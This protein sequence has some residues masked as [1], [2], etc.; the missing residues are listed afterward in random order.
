MVTIEQVGNVASRSQ[1]INMAVDIYGNETSWIRPLNLVVSDAIS[2][3]KNPFYANGCGK[4]FIAKKEGK[5]V[6]RILVHM[7]K[8]HHLIHQEKV[9]YF[10]LFECVDDMD[11]AKV[12]LNEA[13]FFAKS[14]GCKILRG[15]FNITAAQEIGILTDGFD[16]VPSIDMVYTKPY[17]PTLLKESGFIPCLKMKTWR[18]DNIE[19][20]NY[21]KIDQLPT[22][23]EQITFRS[24][25]SRK[26]SEEMDLIREVVNSAF[27]GNWGFVPITHEE[28]RMQIGA[29]IPF[30]DPD[31]IIIAE[32]CGI[33]IG[34]T[35]AVPDFNQII[36]NTNGKLIHP[37]ILK[38][39]LPNSLKSA[40][41]I[42]FAVRKQFQNMKISQNLNLELI[43][44]LHKKGY[45]DLSITWISE[46]NISSKKQAEF[47]GMHVLHE[48]EMFEKEI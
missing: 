5:C 45:K 23:K 26:R 42:L 6:G 24:I 40:V 31:L 22:H 44:N 32:S 29:L 7:S 38:L 19:D 21:N 25:N 14:L 16:R 30:L 36:K 39:I 2:F 4:A 3:K 8:F 34:V 1:F 48:L 41:V 37:S 47:L 35:L 9:C 11:V 18:N 13:E 15:P 33:P 20:L 27:L 10:G 28:W 17:Y 43:R 12:L 46:T